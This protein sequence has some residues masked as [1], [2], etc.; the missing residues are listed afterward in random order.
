MQFSKFCFISANKYEI[1]LPLNQ[2]SVSLYFSINI[3]A[4]FTG[5]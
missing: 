2:E 5:V 4:I 3:D 1:E